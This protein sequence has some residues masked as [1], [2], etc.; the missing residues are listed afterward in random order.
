MYLSETRRR[1][2]RIRGENSPGMLLREKERGENDKNVLVQFPLRESLGA[3]LIINVEQKRDAL[4]VVA[5][6][7]VWG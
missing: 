1:V 6:F 4:L 3:I 5:V 7:L 2:T